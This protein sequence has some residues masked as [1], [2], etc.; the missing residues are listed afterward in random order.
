LLCI[1]QVIRAIHGTLPS[2]SLRL[3]KTAVH[4]VI[5]AIHGALPSG[6]LRLC[7]TAIH[8]VIRAIHGALPSG[9]LRL[10][11]TAILPFCLSLSF[12]VKLPSLELFLFAFAQQYISRA[13]PTVLFLCGVESEYS[14]ELRQ[15]VV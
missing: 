2:G 6:S 13:Y 1:C 10:C 5:R 15:P 14:I 11:K 9:S 7:K 4:L 12:I 8:L 3:C